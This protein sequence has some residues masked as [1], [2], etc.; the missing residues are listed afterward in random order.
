MWS[1]SLKRNA[2]A[3]TRLCSNLWIAHCAGKSEVQVQ[4][5]LWAEESRLLSPVS[6]QVP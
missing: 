2:G 1:F 4:K 5:Q 6:W 3:G